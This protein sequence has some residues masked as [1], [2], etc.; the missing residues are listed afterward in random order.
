MRPTVTLVWTVPFLMAAVDP[1]SEAALAGLDRAVTS[2]RYFT[3]AEAPTSHRLDKMPYPYSVLPILIAD[4]PEVDGVLDVDV[5]R[6]DPGST[7]LVRT[8]A[9]DQ[10]LR[11]ALADEPGTPVGQWSTPIDEPYQNMVDRMLRPGELEIEY[12]LATT[13]TMWL[14]SFWTVGPPNTVQEADGLRARP[15]PYDLKIWGQGADDGGSSR[16]VPTSPVC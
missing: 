7:E 6:L 13:N 11:A 4:R 5:E 2:G 16:Y 10:R 9:D 1:D 3:S 14:H 8:S 15:D 12:D